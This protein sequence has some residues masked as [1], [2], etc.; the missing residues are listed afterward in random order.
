[1]AP[2][3]TRNPHNAEHTPGGSSS[4]SAA[5]VAAGMVPLAVGTQ[6]GGSTIRPAAFC[7]VA[8]YVPT[9]GAIP[10][11]GILEQAP[12]LDTVGLFGK[13]AEDV[14]MLGDALFGQDDGD[15]ATSLSPPPR[16]LTTAQTEP[17]VI[18]G[19]AFVRQP[20]WE[21]ADEDT[22]GAFAELQNILGDGCAEVQLPEPF[23][24]ARAAHSR[25][26]L[27]ELAKSYFRYEEQGADHLS[28]E[29]LKGISDGKA[30]PARDYLAARDW[31]RILY[32][33]LEQI[34]SRFD[35]ILTPA[36]PGPAPGLETTG[37]PA[38][39]FLWTF[40]GVPQVTLPLLTAGN[41][42][43]MGVQLVGPRHGDGR[44]LR[45]ARWLAG[46]LA[47]AN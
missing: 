23:D 22:K 11:T 44:L 12:S 31:P 1:M 26:Q 29:T 37:S 15:L 21:E 10:R 32:P 18:P 4:G 2:S 36:A 25:V 40:C 38:F 5:A 39:N 45:T 30:I 17:P 16:L 28:P 7:G 3:K 33:A 27:A 14:A 19:I 24:G 35:V 34:F 6:T 46:R 20:A 47:E 13:T 8:G 9:F 42:L 43:P 41:G